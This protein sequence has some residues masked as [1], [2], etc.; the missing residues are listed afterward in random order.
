MIPRP[1]ILDD[2][3]KEDA[4]SK[5][6]GGRAR[7]LRHNLR[8]FAWLCC[9]CW[10]TAWAALDAPPAGSEP[11]SQEEVLTRLEALGEDAGLSGRQREQLAAEYRDALAALQERERYRVRLRE[12][13]EAAAAAPGRQR[14]IERQLAEVRAG[15]DPVPQTAYRDLDRELAEAE[16]R[17][18]KARAQVEVRAGEVEQLETAAP[19]LQVAID[20][21]RD[22]RQAVAAELAALDVDPGSSQL[23]QARWV[24][25]QARVAASDARLA[26]LEAELRT[27]EPRLALASAGLRLAEAEAELAATQ[28]T[29]LRD[30]LSGRRDEIVERIR[31]QA[32]R[33][34]GQAEQAAGPVAL[35]ARANAELAGRLADLVGRLEGIS[36]AQRRLRSRLEEVRELRDTAIGQLE[37]ARAGGA[38]GRALHRQ[39]Q[40]LPKLAPDPEEIHRRGEVI[41]LARFEQLELRAERKARERIDALLTERLAGLPEAERETVRP[42]LREQ[43]ELGERL[44]ERLGDAYTTYVAELTSLDRLARELVAV[45]DEYADLLNRDLAWIADARRPGW[46]WPVAA[47]TPLL[48]TADP[49]LW[50]ELASAAVRAWQRQPLPLGAA[51]LAVALSFFHRRRLRAWLVRFAEPVDD[52]ERDSFANTL[53][54]L[55]ASLLLALPVPLVLGYAAFLLETG[56]EGARLVDALA[57]G[58]G[59]AALVAL[60]LELARVLCRSR[61]LFDAHLGWPVELRRSLV[62]SLYW[63]LPASVAA[64]LAVAATNALGEHLDTLGRAAFTLGAA[65]LSLFIWRT[66][67]PLSGLL[68]LY[69]VA[70]RRHGWQW[71]LRSLWFGGFALIPVALALLALAG[72]YFT[73]QQL[74]VRFCAS[75]VLAALVAVGIQVA[76]RGLR[77]FEVRLARRQ[78]Q[79]HRETSRR[80]VADGES[81]GESGVAVE[82]ADRIDVGSVNVQVRTF[83]K[84]LSVLALAV[85]LWWIWVDLLPALAALREIVLWE[86]LSGSG[87]QQTPAAVTAADL[88]WALAIGVLTF[89]AAR[90]LPGLLEVAVLQRLEVDAGARYAANTVSRYLIITVGVLVVVNLLG[91]EWGRLQWLVA[92]LGVGLGFGLQEVVANFVSGLII[93]FERPFRIGDT[94]TV[95]SVTGTVSRIRIRATTITDWDRKELIVPNKAFIT[96]Q[97]VNW[98]LSDPVLR[99]IVPVG[100]AY[101]SDTALARQLLMEVATS[102]SRALKDPPPQ[103]WFMGF[104]DSSLNFEVRVFVMGLPEL[105]PTTHELHEGIDAAF[106]RHGVEISFPQRDLHLRSLDPRVA[107]LLRGQS[108]PGGPEAPPA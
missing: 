38:L 26:A 7:R 53:G 54:A 84:I 16:T 20:A 17:L 5:P 52:P 93:L 11:L 75:V 50:G 72:Y 2:L 51:L 58:L 99:V 74:L 65:A 97:L 106:R 100:I 25:L 105:L 62:Q 32:S 3:C 94:V 41:A 12:L 44:R 9:V 8:H 6:A 23:K 101:G 29:A 61:G 108:L 66:L 80:R 96:D 107:E 45:T 64:T 46:N 34:A 13:E 76:L 27:L 30:R 43:L 55:L 19:E 91:L 90:N 69:F 85:G 18:S 24:A 15:P 28:V 98:T 56:A 31:D 35:E 89:L 36:E 1:I 102:N 83:L 48:A 88:G 73:A 4:M 92:A 60:V 42:A 70:A 59:A 82:D 67:H 47:L 37:I 40:E 63:L 95:G 33:L 104:G 86:Y 14:E 49:G 103:V 21:A 10:A 78:A 68:S 87:E 22:R 79:A 81:R 39:R 71:N 57:R 77:L